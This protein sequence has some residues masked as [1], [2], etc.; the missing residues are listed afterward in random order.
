MQSDDKIAIVAPVI[1]FLFVAIYYLMIGINRLNSEYGFLS[2]VGSLG[3]PILVCGTS[4][5]IVAFVSMF[6]LQMIEGMTFFMAGLA[7]LYVYHADVVAV[8]DVFRLI[9]VI[10]S[11]ILVY[12]SYRVRDLRVMIFNILMVFA[13]IAAMNTLDYSSQNLVVASTLILGGIVAL[14]G[15][16]SEWIYF[17]DVV[18][19]R[20]DEFLD[21][22]DDREKE[23]KS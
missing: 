20:G 9:V 11:L 23:S 2:D 21:F 14:I 7:A 6:K 17:Q 18:I 19:D 22:A 10:V 1:G 13:F 5:L 12:I 3:I 16:V 8:S 15:A 4:I